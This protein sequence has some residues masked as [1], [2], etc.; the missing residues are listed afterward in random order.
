MAHIGPNSLLF[1]ALIQYMQVKIIVNY[2]T[3]GKRCVQRQQQCFVFLVGRGEGGW[4]QN[5]LLGVRRKSMLTAYLCYRNECG[6]GA[7]LPV[8][9]DTG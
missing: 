9:V 1:D 3:L 4:H 5:K 7:P 6:E 8:E 2:N